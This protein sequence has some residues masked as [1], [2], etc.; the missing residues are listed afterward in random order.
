MTT[1]NETEIAT[2]TAGHEIGFR[3]DF[4]NAPVCFHLARITF[5]LDVDAANRHPCSTLDLAWLI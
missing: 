2:V 1:G 3:I 4:W 5:E